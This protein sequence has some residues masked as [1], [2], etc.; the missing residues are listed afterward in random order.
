[1]PQITPFLLCITRVT[2]A[3]PGIVAN[4]MCGVVTAAG[5]LAKTTAKIA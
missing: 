1:M 2:G 5:F 4:L 3:S